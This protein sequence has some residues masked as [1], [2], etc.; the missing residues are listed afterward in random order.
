MKNT[1]RYWPYLAGLPLLV[2]F[3]VAAFGGGGHGFTVSPFHT[4][5][6]G[7][8]CLKVVGPHADWNYALCNSSPFVLCYE[9]TPANDYTWTVI[10][11]QNKDCRAMYA[12]L[13]KT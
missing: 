8:R 4:D 13:K 11:V 6:N 3:V 12:A 10:P 5:V 7:R 2:V 9:S 1:R